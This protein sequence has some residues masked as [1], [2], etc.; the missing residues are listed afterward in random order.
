MGRIVMTRRCDQEAQHDLLPDAVSRLG[1]RLLTKRAV[2][3]RVMLKH[4]LPADVDLAHC[5]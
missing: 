2:S 1:L 4:N 5:D 3:C